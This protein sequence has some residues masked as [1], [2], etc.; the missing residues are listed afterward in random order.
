MFELSLVLYDVTNSIFS[1]HNSYVYILLIL[2]VIYY[3][4]PL[5]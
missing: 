2:S 1:K 4:Y 5:K 3:Y